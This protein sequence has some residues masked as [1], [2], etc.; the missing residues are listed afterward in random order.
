MPIRII[1]HYKKLE[2]IKYVNYSMVDSVFENDSP[3]GYT[4]RLDDFRSI[5]GSA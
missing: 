3:A 4:D 2:V 1:H 5:C